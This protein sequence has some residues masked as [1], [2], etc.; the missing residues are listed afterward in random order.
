[1]DVHPGVFR[2]AVARGRNHSF[3]VL[4]RINILHSFDS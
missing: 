2:V 1:M 3:P 4:A